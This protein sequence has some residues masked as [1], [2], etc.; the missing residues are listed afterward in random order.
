MILELPKQERYRIVTEKR[1][2]NDDT[3]QDTFPKPVERIPLQDCTN[4]KIQNGDLESK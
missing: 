4:D 1:P 3:V 2:D